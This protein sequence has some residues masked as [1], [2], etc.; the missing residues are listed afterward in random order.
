MHVFASATFAGAVVPHDDTDLTFNALYVGSLG[1]VSIDLPDGTA[2]V[3]V[4]VIAGT[5]L[6]VAG[7][8]VNAATT[9]GDIVWLQW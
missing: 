6:P 2:V 3:F 1:D 7:N 8:R 4:G 5:I 9:A